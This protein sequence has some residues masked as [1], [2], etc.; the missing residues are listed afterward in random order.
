[1]ASPH[2]AGT[3]ALMQE[4]YPALTAAE[5]EAYLEASAIPLP[6][7]CRSVFDIT[8]GDF[9]DVCWESDATGAGLLDVPAVLGLLP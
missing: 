4:A 5:A 3:V 1:M 6:A 7:G 2:V 9:A 8:I